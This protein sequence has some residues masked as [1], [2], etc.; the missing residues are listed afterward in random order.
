MLH[1]GGRWKAERQGDD[2]SPRKNSERKT[3]F[4]D[5]NFDNRHNIRVDTALRHRT[6]CVIQTRTYRKQQIHFPLAYYETHH[7]R[8]DDEQEVIECEL[9]IG[10]VYAKQRAGSTT[11]VASVH[12]THTSSF[13]QKSTCG[14]TNVIRE[15]ET[16]GKTYLR[17]PLLRKPA[18]RRH[19]R[20]TMGGC[21]FVALNVLAPR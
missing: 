11:T 9:R 4:A 13:C 3:P 7:R 8:R 12:R 1:F 5:L 2:L 20:T 16:H 6:E 19:D 10:L 17:F 14:F 18:P 15:S 21:F